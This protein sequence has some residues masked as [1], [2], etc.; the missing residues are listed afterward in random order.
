MTTAGNLVFQ[1]ARAR[2]FSAFRADTGESVWTTDTQANIVG[3]S[4][5]YTVGGEQYVAVVA[6]G[7][8]GFGGSYWAPNHARLLVYKLGGKAMLPEAV[9]YTPPP[10]NPP[11]E[12]G[13][14]ALLAQG[15]AQLHRALRQLAT[16]TSGRVSSVFPDLRYAGALCERR[17][18]QGD[19]DRWRAAS[20]TAWCRSGRC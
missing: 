11:E 8:G 3:G 16:A 12:F 15:E 5:T 20:R 18:V 13:D 10:L 7:Q 9:A 4:V 2:A 19:R 14:A 6:A 17:S 1:G